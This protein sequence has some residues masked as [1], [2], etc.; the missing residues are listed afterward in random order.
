MN[1]SR[2]R[3]VL[4]STGCYPVVL[5]SLKARPRLAT[6]GLRYGPSTAGVGDTRGGGPLPLRFVAD[7]SGR[8]PDGTGWQPVLPRI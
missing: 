5:G 3:R 2:C 8:L 4:G 1:W 6:A 7:P